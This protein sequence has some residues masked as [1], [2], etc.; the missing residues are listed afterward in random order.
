MIN[1][2]LKNI[3]LI[4]FALVGPITLPAG[5]I[6]KSLHQYKNFDNSKEI[7]LTSN[8]SFY[9]YPKI[10]AKKFKPLETGSIL[11]ILQKWEVDERDIW[12]RVELAT[13]TLFENPNNIRRGW[14][15]M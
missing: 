12:V 14:I 2:F 8:C 1:N 10:T 15:K 3:C 4:S 13:N 6:Q 11:S 7:I 5:G 9:T